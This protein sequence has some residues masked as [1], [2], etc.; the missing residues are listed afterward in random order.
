M[1]VSAQEP[2]FRIDNP[3]ALIRARI[4][5][6]RIFEAR[7]LCRQLGGELGPME[8]SA[9]EGE[10][11]KL[12]S[13]VDKLRKQA[14]VHAA[15]GRLQLAAKVYREIERI[16]IDVPDVAAERQRIDGGA[17]SLLVQAAATGAQATAASSTEPDAVAPLRAEQ[18]SLPVRP[19]RRMPRSL[20]SFPRRWLVLALG[21]LVFCGLLSFF[22]MRNRTPDHQGSAIIAAPPGRIVIRPIV[23]AQPAPTA[24]K[25]EKATGGQAAHDAGPEKGAALSIGALQVR[26]GHPE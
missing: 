4:R 18:V 2:E 15:A 13:Q 17:G 9:L 26:P 1:P 14:L 10:L 25:A 3:S 19:S 5:E 6:K 12:L 20:P 21:L 24:E 8:K 7:F 23:S 22:L 11:S 16:A